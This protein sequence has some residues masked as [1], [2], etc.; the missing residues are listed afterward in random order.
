MKKLFLL[1]ICLALALSVFA[2]AEAGAIICL[3]C[4]VNGETFLSIDGPVT[5]TA[6]ADMKDGQTLTGWKL[7]GQVVEGETNFWLLF[8]ADGNTVVEA[9][10][11]EASSAET[12]VSPLDPAPAEETL[13]DS[14]IKGYGCSFQYL[15][16]NG[17]GEGQSYTELPFD[18]SISFRVTADD[19][20][21]SK[22]DYWVINGAKYSFPNTLKYITVYNLTQPMTF[23][24][25]YKNKSAQ[26]MGTFPCKG[27][28]QVV[29]C[30]NAHIRF[31]KGNAT[32][33]GDS[34]K[35][36][37]FTEP[38]FNVSSGKNCDGGMIDVK[39]T[40]N[41]GEDSY[42]RYWEI[43]GAR[44]VFNADMSYIIVKGL[45]ES[46]HYVPHVIAWA[47]SG[48]PGAPIDDEPRL[49]IPGFFIGDRI[50]FNG[51][52]IS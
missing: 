35:E 42:V 29:S 15:N 33:G 1:L 20:H 38:Y 28:R 51:M 7:N 47:D 6:I 17:I 13:V 27:S 11:G 4:S 39:I 16:G 22:I 36:F 30:E 52:L 31:I 45:G 19:P 14:V 9:I 40:A 24:V 18:G 8:T 50:Q 46:T 25:V 34:F 21:A 49:A 10:L 41:C 12:G 5:M 26:T 37:D 23:E 44:F 48:D 2:A 32:T 3:K 43:N